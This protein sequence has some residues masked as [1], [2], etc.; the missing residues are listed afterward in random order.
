[1]GIWIYCGIIVCIWLMLLVHVYCIQF[2][3]H[4]ILFTCL[5]LELPWEKYEQFLFPGGWSNGE[6][7]KNAE[8]KNVGGKLKF[9]EDL[10]VEITVDNKR[11]KKVST[12]NTKI[13]TSL[14]IG[15]QVYIYWPILNEFLVNCYMLSAV[16]KYRWTC[17]IRISWTCSFS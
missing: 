16:I 13:D 1:M 6:I 5:Y 14:G 4:N 17:Y 8:P 11:I 2:Q 10:E 7:K 15:I 3:F 12:K 9:D